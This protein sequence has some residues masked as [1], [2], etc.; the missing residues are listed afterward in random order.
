MPK[1]DKDGMTEVM[2][3]VIMTLRVGAGIKSDAG[4]CIDL[5]L[6]NKTAWVKITMNGKE[7]CSMPLRV[8]MKAMGEF[9]RCLMEIDFPAI[10][11]EQ[12]EQDQEIRKKMVM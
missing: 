8:F 7:H 6:I 10:A 9:N 1:D 5:A 3:K 11:Q 4:M 12:E 2:A